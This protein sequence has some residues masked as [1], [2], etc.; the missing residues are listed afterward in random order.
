MNPDGSQ[1][2]IV[3][4]IARNDSFGASSLLKLATMD[5]LGDVCAGG[6]AEQFAEKSEKANTTWIQANERDVNC[7]HLT[8]EDMR[9]IPEFELNCISETIRS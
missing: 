4:V 5:Y 6:E 3:C 7:W 9:R 8:V 2:K 1:K